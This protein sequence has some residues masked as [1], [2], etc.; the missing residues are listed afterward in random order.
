MAGFLSACAKLRKLG[1]LMKQYNVDDVH[2]RVR[3]GT[4]TRYNARFDGPQGIQFTFPHLALV[5][6]DPACRRVAQSQIHRPKHP[7]YYRV[8]MIAS[9]GVFLHESEIASEIVDAMSEFMD[10]TDPLPQVISI[11]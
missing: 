5:A 8:G 1:G 10:R 7:T 11:D 3:S 6:L 2:L 9:A 4:G